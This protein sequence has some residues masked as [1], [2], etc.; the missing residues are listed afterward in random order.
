MGKKDQVRQLTVSPFRSAQPKGKQKLKADVDIQVTSLGEIISDLIT[1]SLPH[2]HVKI[3]DVENMRQLMKVVSN[4][5]NGLC[6][7]AEMA[8]RL[9]LPKDFLSSES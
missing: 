6:P 9:H 2:D 8:V 1:L 4:Q 5:A 3:Q 7:R